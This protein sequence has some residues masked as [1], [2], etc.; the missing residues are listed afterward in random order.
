M[1]ILHITPNSNG[2]EEVELIANRIRK[3]NHLA[4]IVKNGMEFMT[5]GFLINDTPQIRAVLDNIPKEKQY[6]FVVD[7]KKDPFVKLYHEEDEKNI[8]FITLDKE[9]GIALNSFSKTKGN[10]KTNKF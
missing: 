2:Y 7:F 1:K 8:D 6:E 9:I 5:G 10:K 3:N 4:L